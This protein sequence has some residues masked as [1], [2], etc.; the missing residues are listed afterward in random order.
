V[1]YTQ[2]V[3]SAESEVYGFRRDLHFAGAGSVEDL[4]DAMRETREAFE[5]GRRAR[6]FNCVLARNTR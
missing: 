2:Q 6:T 3:A 5:P 4:F 1:E